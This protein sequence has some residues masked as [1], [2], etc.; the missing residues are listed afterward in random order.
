MQVRM[1]A[2]SQVGSQ[3]RVTSPLM[4]GQSCTC[5]GAVVE[6][7]ADRGGAHG[8]FVLGFLYTPVF[9]KRAND[10]GVRDGSGSQDFHRCPQRTELLGTVTEDNHGNPIASNGDE[11]K[12]EGEENRE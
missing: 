7:F 5:K 4:I 1:K 3:V 8:S 11:N 10:N 6:A 9:D 2:D 12:G